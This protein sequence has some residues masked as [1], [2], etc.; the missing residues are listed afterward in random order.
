MSAYMKGPG[1]FEPD[2]SDIDFYEDKAN[3]EWEGKYNDFK[4]EISDLVASLVHSIKQEKMTLP[5]MVNYDLFELCF[6][7]GLDAECG[8]LDKM[9]IK[10]TQLF[11]S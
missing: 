6:K 10:T 2:C 1:D 9:E 4:D 8:I 3:C 5:A 11:P 7:L